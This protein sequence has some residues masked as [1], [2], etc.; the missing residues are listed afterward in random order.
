MSGVDCLGA[1]VAA[2]GAFAVLF[3]VL[4]VLHCLESLY[5]PEQNELAFI[6]MFSWFQ[7]KDDAGKKA[8]AKVGLTMPENKVTTASTPLFGTQIRWAI[9]V[10]KEALAQRRAKKLA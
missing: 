5:L 3:A 8:G 10:I 7:R 1:G 4:T 2:A 9:S 6:E